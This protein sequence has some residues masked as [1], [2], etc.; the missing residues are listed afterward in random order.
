MVAAV[1]HANDL[2]LAATT[3]V[4]KS[5]LEN[6]M[7]DRGVT[8]N[9]GAGALVTAQPPDRVET[10]PEEKAQLNLFLYQVK[11]KGMDY[12]SRASPGEDE[13]WVSRA[14]AFELN[15]LITAYGGEDLQPEL[16]L[17][18]V[19][20]AFAERPVLCGDVIGPAL[21]FEGH[22][23]PMAPGFAAMRK[24]GLDK[25][26]REIRMNLQALTPDEMFNI[27]STLQA[28]FRPSVV[29]RVQVF[30]DGAAQEGSEP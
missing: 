6:G 16:L 9:V 19:V 4:L 26:L 28:T 5:F 24:S 7:V 25:R 13:R 11:P 23:K 27:W 14:A 18:F 29:Y 20:E 15:Y 17:G 8:A 21:A 1:A 3:A 12:G 22:G 10:G 30:R 2:T